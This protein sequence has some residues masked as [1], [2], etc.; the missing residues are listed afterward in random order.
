[1]NAQDILASLRKSEK[2]QTA[3]IYK[4]HG[5]GD[6]V[7]GVLTSE[8]AKVSKRIKLDDAL[9]ADLW[10]TGNAEAR[11]LALQVTDPAKVGRSDAEKFLKDG[12][13]RFLGCYLSALLARSPVADEVMRA[14]MRSPEEDA[15]EVGYGIL[16]ARLKDDSESVSD[17]EA[18]ALLTAIEREIHSSP[19]RARHAMNAALIALGVFKPALRHKAARA[20]KRIGKVEVDHGETGCKT[21]DAAEYI[22]KASRRKV[23]P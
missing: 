10:K 18:R 22:E 11:I 23:C 9:A 20:A 13:A 7:F 5:A 8:L 6:N 12:P 3:A 1:M 16:A 2:P 17:A 4:R 21:P 15:R 19:N 14:W